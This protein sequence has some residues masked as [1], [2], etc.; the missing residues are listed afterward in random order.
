MDAG[1]TG[2]AVILGHHRERRLSDGLLGGE[3]DIG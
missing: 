1:R 3:I 2:E